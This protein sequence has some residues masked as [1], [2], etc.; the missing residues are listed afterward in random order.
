[1]RTYKNGKINGWNIEKE[2]RSYTSF[3]CIFFHTSTVKR[4]EG[5]GPMLLIVNTGFVMFKLETSLHPVLL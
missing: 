1:M 4:Q 3:K 2:S 5:S